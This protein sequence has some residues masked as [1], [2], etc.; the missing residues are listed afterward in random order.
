LPVTL[1]MRV[2]RAA[3]KKGSI[4]RAVAMP[5]HSPHA[6]HPS[7]FR[8]LGWGA[9]ALASSCCC[10]RSATLWWLAP[11]SHRSASRI[12]IIRAGEEGGASWALPPRGPATRFFLRHSGGRA[13]SS[14]AE[15][16]FSSHAGEGELL[17]PGQ[18]AAI[19]PP[20][21]RRSSRARAGHV[22]VSLHRGVAQHAVRREGGTRVLGRS[23]SRSC[24][25]NGS[26]CRCTL[27]RPPLTG[28]VLVG[29]WLLSSVLRRWSP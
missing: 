20:P 18:G 15:E 7:T 26:A 25:K 29:R 22:Q 9:P 6:S 24:G 14:S 13:S 21:G 17:L 12:F 8:A 27:G 16:A 19:R 23:R 4:P 2:G 3:F 28:A 1:G 10:W 5:S 11:F